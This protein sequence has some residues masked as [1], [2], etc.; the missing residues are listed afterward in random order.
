[1]KP[2]DLPTMPLDGTLLIEASA[3][4]G[5]THT[6]A[7]LYVRLVLERGYAPGSIL[8]VTF[9]EAAT[10]E[11]RDRIR[12]NLMIALRVAQGVEPACDPLL[13]AILARQKAG[14]T[15]SALCLKRALINFDEAAIF[16]I[17]GFC[18]RML[19]QYCFESGMLFHTELVA[20]Q[21]EILQEIIDDF[22]FQTFSAAHPLLSAV[23]QKEKFTLAR[24]YELAELV[25]RKPL[26]EI[27]PP[28]NP[29]AVPRL[30]DLYERLQK[31][32]ERDS[33]Q[34]KNL[35]LHATGLTRTQNT[36][37]HDRLKILFKQLEAAVENVPTVETLSSIESFAS[38]TLSQNLTARG[39]AP[40]HEFFD[41][42]DSFLTAQ[43]Q[44]MIALTHRFVRWCVSELS[45]RKRRRNVQ[46][47]NDLL[48]E[49]LAALKTPAGMSLASSIRKSFSAALIDEFQDTDP[50]QYA[51][52]EHLFHGVPGQSLFLI[53][54]PK[55]S[56]Y[57]FRG[58]DIFSYLAAS[59]NT[60]A[61][62]KYTLVT[63]WRSEHACVEAVNHLFG[64]VRNP[65][66]LREGIRYY[67]TTAAP[68]SKGN[69]EP[70]TVEGKPAAGMW[71]W[72]LPTKNNSYVNKEDALRTAAEAVV[73]EIARLLNLASRRKALIGQR[74]VQPSDIAILVLRNRDA[75][76]FV[77]PLRALNIPV[78]VAQAESIFQTD[79]AQE[80][81][82]ILR[83]LV[84]P[85]RTDLLHAALATPILGFTAH[86]L[87]HLVEDA[88]GAAAHEEHS[89]RFARYADLWATK[90]FMR[91]FRTVLAQY[92]VRENLLGLPGGERKLTNILHLAELLHEASL[93][94]NLGPSGLLSYLVQQRSAPSAQEEHELRLER[95]DE[96]VQI[97]TVFKS[98]GLEYPIVFCPFM[99]QKGALTED[100][101]AIY[102]HNSHIV[103]DLGSEHYH[104]A[105]TAA[106]EERLAELVRLLYV[107]VTRAKN[108]CYLVCG[109][110]GKE[111]TATALDY[112]FSTGADQKA[113]A[114]TLASP[115]CTSENELLDA[116]KSR[117]D[118]ACSALHFA[119]PSL[120]QPEPYRAPDEPGRLSSTNKTF[121]EDWICRD[122]GIASYSLLTA[123]EHL[124]PADAEDTIVKHD[125]PLIAAGDAAEAE[126]F[127]AFPRGALAGSCVHA[128]FERLDFTQRE[129]TE[130]VIASCLQRYGLYQPTYAT[131]VRAMLEQ[132]LAAPLEPV[133]GLVL[134]NIGRR[135][136][137]SELAFFYPLQKITPQ[138]L[139][140]LFAQH[141]PNA[142]RNGMVERIE[143]LV[144]HPIQGF[145]RGFIDM[146]IEHDGKY[147]LF[148]WKTNYLG[149]LYADYA[150]ERLRTTMQELHY[151]LQYALYT[152]ALHKYLSQHV[153][154]YSYERCFGG[155]FYLFV[156][157][158]T[159]ELPG[160]GIFYDM[161]PQSFIEAFAKLTEVNLSVPE[162]GYNKAIS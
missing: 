138:R 160:N 41:L 3:G 15:Q 134:K 34:I 65:F 51:I 136:R 9:T 145:M 91:M 151:T 23:A 111:P 72:F 130:E 129:G 101:D 156:R 100:K 55:Q 80:L 116:V 132:V 141:W 118:A 104:D 58:A 69:T 7:H 46:S 109:R 146:V 64:L 123:A 143:E 154:E 127:F 147:Y 139:A 22:W 32:W 6:I 40:H 148:D 133:Q 94:Q 66:V 82:C 112:I 24:C 27:V 49:L 1:M 92:R 78:V 137:L 62:K 86:D 26:L 45:R 81:E 97:L 113:V 47:F 83:A 87:R 117:V 16:T 54:D 5:K 159:P 85:R 106:A 11:L 75:Q 31:V 105:Q 149:N 124:V 59:Q 93:N 13:E 88:D 56:I 17:H 153:P 144:F 90:G 128:L 79:E 10:K 122:W 96:A 107:G 103:L 110:I 98:K 161:P 39:T 162:S 135:N 25:L 21:Q 119:V 44:V 37:R 29:E 74:P 115:C 140:A 158:M 43:Q 50:V 71:L 73:R 70:L 60:A 99:W 63:N 18:K 2:L 125:E 114:A 48:S 121:S 57:G 52:F 77:E 61:E 142:H 36:Y 120:P 89:E 30:H 12:K 20:D 33:A 42:C 131:A 53:G 67:A 8:V 84:M 108:R 102:H 19:S 152:V 126:G 28:P 155:V 68:E 150:P 95:D 76:L 35:L 157:G 14:S 38:R 4:T